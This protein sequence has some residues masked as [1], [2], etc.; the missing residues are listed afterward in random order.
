MVP[1]IDRYGVSSPQGRPMTSADDG[2]L[3]ANAADYASIA[4]CGIRGG[5]AAITG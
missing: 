3:L 1:F 4:G 2:I 5:V